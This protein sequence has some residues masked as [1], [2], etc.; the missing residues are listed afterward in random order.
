MK[1]AIA[2]IALAAALVAAP[3]FAED[4]N[5]LTRV[6]YHP[7]FSKQEKEAAEKACLIEGQAVAAKKRAEFAAAGEPATT[8]EAFNQGKAIGEALVDGIMACLP[9]KGYQSLELTPEEMAT[10]NRFIRQEKQTAWLI[11]L[12]KT[13]SAQTPAPAP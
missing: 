11:E 1:N 4:Q 13:K 5:G 10:Y 8:A 6:W 12:A 3:T 2:A 9:T 7:T